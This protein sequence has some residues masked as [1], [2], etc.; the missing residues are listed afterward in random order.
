MPEDESEELES[1]FLGL[2]EVD[3]GTLLLADPAYILPSE[4]Q[5]KP[6]LDYA[7]IFD[8]P[9]PAGPIGGRPVLLVQDFGGDGT[10][11][12]FGKFDGADLVSVTVYLFEPEEGE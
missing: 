1:R 8:A 12:V 4:E 3:S 6:G 11:P 7:A 2:V 5:N 9:R 10:F